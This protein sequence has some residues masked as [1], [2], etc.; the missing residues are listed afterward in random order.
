MIGPVGCLQVTEMHLMLSNV[1]QAFFFLL[2]LRCDVDVAAA[3]TW[4]L[5][6]HGSRALLAEEFTY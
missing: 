3:E 6:K 4:R 1:T 5:L 2:L